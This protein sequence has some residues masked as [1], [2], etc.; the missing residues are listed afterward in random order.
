MIQS[1]DD[2]NGNLLSKVRSGSHGEAVTSTYAYNNYGDWVWRR[3]RHMLTG[4]STGKVR[5]TGT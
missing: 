3:T 5:E 2:T 1:Y 4:F